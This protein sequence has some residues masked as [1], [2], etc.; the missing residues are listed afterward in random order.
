MEPVPSAHELHMRL[1]PMAAVFEEGL[2]L[3]QLVARPMEEV[4][5][6][7]SAVSAVEGKAMAAVAELRAEAADGWALQA[8]P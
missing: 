1:V 7:S 3:L 4:G 5:L 2:Q 8:E 6:S